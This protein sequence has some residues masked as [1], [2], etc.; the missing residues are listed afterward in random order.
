MSRKVYIAVAAVLSLGLLGAASGCVV[1]ETKSAT[2]Q[3]QKVKNTDPT[4]GWVE[5]KRGVDKRCDGSTMIYLYKYKHE[6]GY[7]NGASAAMTSV[8]NAEDCLK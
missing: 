6:T 7:G 3:E 1:E 5:W 4:K 8:P 2:T